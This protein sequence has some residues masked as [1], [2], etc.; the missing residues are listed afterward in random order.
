MSAAG[1]QARQSGPLGESRGWNRRGRPAWWGGVFTAIT[2]FVADSLPDG[3][4]EEPKEENVVG[5]MDKRG[6][7]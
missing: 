3:L 7:S 4:R 2:L 6:R 5:C 1:A